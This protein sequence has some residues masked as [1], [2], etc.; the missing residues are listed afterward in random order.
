MTQ[1][2]ERRN[3]N[4]Y[5]GKRNIIG[6]IVLITSVIMIFAVLP[7]AL[8]TG[9]RDNKNLEERGKTFLCRVADIK[10]LNGNDIVVEYVLDGH[11]YSKVRTAPSQHRIAV[12]DSLKMIYDSLDHENVMIIFN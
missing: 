9:H 10:G 12:G 4:G 7:Y 3:S 11:K 8:W 6:Y 2:T 5:K 1:K